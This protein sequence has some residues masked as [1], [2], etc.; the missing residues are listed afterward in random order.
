MLL[1]SRYVIPVSSAFDTYIEY[2]AVLVEDDRIVEVG[3]AADLMA[4]HPGEEVRDFGMAAIMPGFVDC[5][6]HLEFSLMRGILNDTPYASWKAFINEKMALLTIKDWF[7]SAY[8]GAYEALTAGITCVADVT[9]TG[10]CLPAIAELGLRGIVY[11]SVGA[12][13]RKQV[14]EEM[15]RAVEQI[16]QWR[17]QVAD[18][19]RIQIGIAPENLFSCHPQILKEVADFANATGTPVAMHLAG[20]QEECDFIRYG[21]SV[22]SIANDSSDHQAFAPRQSVE[23]LPAGCTPVQYALN[24]DILDVPQLLAVHCVKLEDH[25]IELL[26]DHG[27]SV[28]VT[29]RACAKLGQGLARIPEMRRAGIAVGLGSDSPAASDSMD[30]IA[31]M[32]FA[33][34]ALRATHGKDGFIEGPDM[35]R[36]ATLDS[37]RALGLDDLVGSLD[38]GK[39]ADI[40]AIDLSD[41]RQAPTHFPTSAVVHTSS[42]DDVM[43]TMVDG[44]I[45]YD[46]ADKFC[47][48]P[49]AD[50]HEMRRITQSLETV[51]RRLRS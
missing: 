49:N 14:E 45:V 29:P 20:S 35:I 38:P 46:A 16:G 3:T 24:W 50:T 30:P 1:T 11:R 34:L 37:A 25:D 41:S 33:M 9:S 23:L 48:V 21:S 40:I 15:G 5:H 7:D 42:R 2:G 6:S 26:R 32:R 31:E 43:M 12:P 18:T 47:Q 13:A 28:A 8:I 39:K 22:F 44:N 36:M 27:V 10:A 19:D 4:R 51:R 17:G